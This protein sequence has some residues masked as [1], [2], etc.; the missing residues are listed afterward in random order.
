MPRAGA[1][2][3]THTMGTPH[4]LAPWATQGTPGHTVALAWPRHRPVRYPLPPRWAP[5]PPPRSVWP[6][7][8]RT[9]PPAAARRSS[10]THLRRHLRRH[11]R[12]CGWRLLAGNQQPNRTQRIARQAAR[13]RAAGSKQQADKGQHAGWQ[14][15]AVQ[16]RGVL[17]KWTQGLHLQVLVRAVPIL[18]AAAELQVGVIS[19]GAHVPAPPVS[20]TGTCCHQ[21]HRMAALPR[22]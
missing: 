17:A 1:L 14:R 7:S 22:Q 6:R 2:P 13:T 10:A 11:L 19:A 8:D 12:Q 16:R 4:E 3:Q 15:A 9:R 20:H 21:K 5:Q 18:H